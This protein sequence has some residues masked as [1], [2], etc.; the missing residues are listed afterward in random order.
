MER[1]VVWEK[2]AAPCSRLGVHK[3]Y[4]AP[5]RG[6]VHCNGLCPHLSLLS[7]REVVT[8]ERCIG[9]RHVFKTSIDEM[10]GY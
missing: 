1:S 5:S 2:L 8:L 10:R 9:C 7:D 6:K 4:Q 3:L